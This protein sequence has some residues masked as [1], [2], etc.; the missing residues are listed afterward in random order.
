MILDIIDC[1]VKILIIF[2]YKYSWHNWPSNVC[3]SSH[4]TQCLLLH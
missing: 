2:R 1:N 4:L 3:L